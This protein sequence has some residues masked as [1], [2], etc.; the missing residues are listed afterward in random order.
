[1]VNNFKLSRFNAMLF[2]QPLLKQLDHIRSFTVRLN[3]NQEIILHE[4]IGNLTQCLRRIQY[5]TTL[6][7]ELRSSRDEALQTR[8]RHLGVLFGDLSFIFSKMAQSVENLELII[9]S[10]SLLGRKQSCAYCETLRAATAWVKNLRYSGALCPSFFRDLAHNLL[11]KTETLVINMIYLLRCTSRD[12][13][14]WR[15]CW[16]PRRAL[17]DGVEL[18]TAARAV[19]GLR[20]MPQ[21]RRLEILSMLGDATHSDDPRTELGIVHR[22]IVDNTAAVYPCIS[23]QPCSWIRYQESPHHKMFE[24]VVKFN[25]VAIQLEGQNWIETTFG[26]RYPADYKATSEGQSGGYR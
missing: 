20:K 21:I 10:H 2:K 3:G 5:L 23:A 18:A 7:Q 6:S 13:A 25:E 12:V 8:C 26:A 16:Q 1:M 19:L 11:T 14:L 9:S 17:D 24:K 4:D 22:N 15:C